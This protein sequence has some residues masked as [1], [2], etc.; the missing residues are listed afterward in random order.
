MHEILKSEI[1]SSYVFKTV[2]KVTLKPKVEKEF[3]D[4]HPFLSACNLAN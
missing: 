3:Y 2:S 4:I 1:L